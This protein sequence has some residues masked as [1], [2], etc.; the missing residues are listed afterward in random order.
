MK[1]GKLM[2]MKWFRLQDISLIVIQN[3]MFASS[4][5]MFAEVKRKIVFYFVGC[6]FS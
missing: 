5:L 2:F 1:A 3:L 4:N 6:Y